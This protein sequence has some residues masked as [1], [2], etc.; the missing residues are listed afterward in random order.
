[1]RERQAE[2]PFRLA[3]IRLGGLVTLIF[4]GYGGPSPRLCSPY[5]VAGLCAVSCSGRGAVGTYLGASRAWLRRD[6]VPSS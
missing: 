1:M 6:G 4:L 5:S 2:R 3:A